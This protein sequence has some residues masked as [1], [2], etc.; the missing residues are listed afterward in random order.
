MRSVAPLVL[1]SLALAGCES[2]RG[3]PSEVIS[4]SE[5]VETLRPYF[6]DSQLKAYYD[7]PFDADEE[8]KRRFRNQIIST[9]M[10]AVDRRYS[11]FVIDLSK[12][13]RGG[14]FATSLTSIA[15]TGT[16]TLLKVELVKNILTS[17]DTGLKGATQ[18]F[19]KDI[20][21]ERTLTVLTQQM[22]AERTRVAT[23]IWSSLSKST[24]EFPLALALGKVDDY[25]RAGTLNVALASAEASASNEAQSADKE[26]DRKVLNIVSCENDPTNA[27]LKKWIDDGTDAQA[28]A[29]DQLI[30]TALNNS[31]IKVDGQVPQTF[32]IIDSCDSRFDALKTQLVRDNGLQG[33]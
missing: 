20:L 16:A 11:D 10:L 32:Q 21:L 29:R 6:T 27:K 7:L 2:F 26:F 23:T 3:A 17:I 19:S 28:T 24:T 14:D 5:E 1:A 25:Y 22:D 15:L 4:A 9:R 33:S 12:S 30:Q 18:A 31:G 13:V 8:Q